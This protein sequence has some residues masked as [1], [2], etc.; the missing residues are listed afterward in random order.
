MEIE[1]QSGSS[2]GHEVRE[3]IKL[4]FAVQVKLQQAVYVTNANEIRSLLDKY[5]VEHSNS[6]DVMFSE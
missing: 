4:L 5:E 2:V 1:E 3:L 6:Y